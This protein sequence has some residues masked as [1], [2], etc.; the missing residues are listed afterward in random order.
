M[1]NGS[2]GRGVVAR[3]YATEVLSGIGTLFHGSVLRE[4]A[5]DLNGNPWDE[6]SIVEDYRISLETRRFGYRIAVVPGAIDDTDAIVDPKGLWKQRTRWA[7]GTW[8]E[9]LRFGSKP[10]TRRVWLSSFMCMSVLILRTIGFLMVAS[11]FIFHTPFTYNFLWL[12]IMG[13]AAIDHI[14]VL[15]NTKNSDGLEGYRPVDHDGS[16][17]DL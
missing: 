13:V 14:D 5:D 8:Q 1:D 16:G 6:D 2:F 9:L 15:R 10:Y 12:I 3:K 4:I 17:R 7:T 11:V